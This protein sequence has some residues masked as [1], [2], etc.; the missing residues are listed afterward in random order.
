[1]GGRE[2]GRMGG[3]ERGSEEGGSE[4]GTERGVGG[5]GGRIQTHCLQ[6]SL[7]INSLFTGIAPDVT[8]DLPM[9]FPTPLLCN[10]VGIIFAGTAANSN[11]TAT[12]ITDIVLEQTG[13]LAGISTTQSSFT[14]AYP[15]GIGILQ[16]NMMIL[17][18]IYVIMYH[19][20]NTIICTLFA[21]TL[22]LHIIK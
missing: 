11:V 1:M 7:Q 13:H 16:R 14:G 9:I 4:G 12:D 8:F 15:A 17:E 19:T 10:Y 5:K 22:V 6:H 20:D 18:C 21:F 2:G 3:R